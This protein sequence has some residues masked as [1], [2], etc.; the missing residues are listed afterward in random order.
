MAH[1]FSFLSPAFFFLLVFQFFFSPS[2]PRSDQHPLANAASGLGEEQDNEGERW[3]N[4]QLTGVTLTVAS[5][6]K[7]SVVA[8]KRGSVHWL[9][10]LSLSLSV[11]NSL[12]LSLSTHSL[13]PALSA[14]S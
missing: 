6:W 1:N 12:S 8:A 5:M 11:S 2:S 10:S 13:P 14:V 7:G 4:A 3:L 9:G